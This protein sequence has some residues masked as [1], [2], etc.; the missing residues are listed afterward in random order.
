MLYVDMALIILTAQVTVYAGSSSSG[1][2]LDTYSGFSPPSTKT[3]HYSSIYIRFTSD[4]MGTYNGFSASYSTT[5]SVCSGVQTFTAATGSF[6]SNA[7][8]NYQPNMDCGFSISVSGATSITISF[9]HFK[10]E[11]TF[12]QLRIFRGSSLSGTLI[13]TLSGSTIPS[14]VTVTVYHACLV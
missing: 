2:V 11:N 7:V 10:L 9:T 13:T 14:P 6:T 12:D 4:S 5:I 1:R 3:Y 8:G